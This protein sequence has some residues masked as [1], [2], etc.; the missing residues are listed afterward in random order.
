MKRSTVII[1]GAVIVF[2]II[3]LASLKDNIFSPYVPLK[4]AVENPRSHVQVI[5][6]VKKSSVQYKDDGY[7]FII[8]DDGNY[9]MSVFKTGIKPMNFEHAD[10][11]VLIGTFDDKKGIFIADKVL[12]KCPSRYTQGK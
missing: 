1:I 12:T 4:E 5:G 10:Q 8:H 6:K 11:V 9:E 7:S 3:A 2:A